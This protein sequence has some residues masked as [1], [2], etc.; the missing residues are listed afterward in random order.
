MI[1]LNILR[2][3]YYVSFLKYKK[4]EYIIK[5]WKGDN[6]TMEEKKKDLPVFSRNVAA[7]LLLRGFD[8]YNVR[9]NTKYPNRSVFYFRDCQE[10]R[11]A[12]DEINSLTEKM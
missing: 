5:Q 11:D 10:V 9:K 2:T 12:I 3:Y 1:R 8:M 4:R 7:N 6:Y